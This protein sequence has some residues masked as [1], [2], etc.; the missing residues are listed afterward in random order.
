MMGFDNT[1]TDNIE[2]DEQL[3]YGKLLEASILLLDG[4]GISWRDNQEMKETP[5]RFATFWY[6]FLTEHKEVSPT[7]FDSQGFDDWIVVDNIRVYTVCAHHLLPFYCDMTIGY[8]ADGSILGLS[9]IPRIAQKRASMPQT[10]EV[11]CVQVLEDVVNATGAEYAFVKASGVHM[12]MSMRGV[13]SEGKTNTMRMTKK[14]AES[15]NELLRLQILI[16]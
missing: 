2:T 11:M 6:D 10:Q 16:K 7:S 8:I 3:D 4:M 13:K 5:K 15:K 1:L 14:L 9:K 12:C